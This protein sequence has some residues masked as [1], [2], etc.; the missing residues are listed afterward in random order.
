MKP[1][2][3]MEKAFTTPVS[4]ERYP[5]TIGY[6]SPVLFMG[7]CFAESIGDK[8]CERKFPSMVNPF[9]VVY[10]PVSVALVLMRI[11]GGTPFGASELH[12]PNNLWFSF[13]HHTSFSSPDREEC[14][15]QINTS[16]AQAHA[17]WG[18][19]EYLAITFGTARVYTHNKLNRVVAN[20]H[21]I[22]AG[23][24]THSLLP[25]DEIVTLWSDLLTE[26]LNAK[27]ELRVILTVSPV[28]HWKDGPVGNQVSKSTLLLAVSQ[29]VERFRERVFYFPSYE[30]LLDEL[31]DYRF[32]ADDMIHLSSTAI[33]YIWNKF[34][35]AAMDA[36]TIKLSLD[37]ERVMAAVNHRPLHPQSEEFANFAKHVVESMDRLKAK[38]PTLNFSKEISILEGH[39]K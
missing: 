27:K 34:R 4:I 39:R 14:L 12:K 20:C 38:Y 16:L 13:Y 1:N 28:R 26:I 10:N 18:K 33:D 35:S 30:I 15:E 5:F 31:S 7:S 32:Y 19:T 29:L 23:E 17:F 2:R 37:I 9:G 3:D 11:M 25:V 22:P 36:D 6:S 24:F 8:M 21:K